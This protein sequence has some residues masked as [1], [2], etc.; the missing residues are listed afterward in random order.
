M[1]EKI[2]I[3][4]D[5]LSEKTA[6][7]AKAAGRSISELLYY[8][9]L[10]SCGMESAELQKKSKAVEQYL[11]G[12]SFKERSRMWDAVLMLCTDY[13]KQGFQEGFYTGLRLMTEL[14]VREQG[15]EVP[16]RP[17]ERE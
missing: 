7:P 8:D 15:R 17:S 9:Y 4:M 10:Q 11:K 13:E 5:Y 3:I 14:R 6:Q 12:F 16:L 1:C 2:Q